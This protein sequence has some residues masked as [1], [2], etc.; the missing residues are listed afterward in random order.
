MCRLLG[1]EAAQLGR[2]NLDQCAD[3]LRAQEVKAGANVT[4]IRLAR[5]LRKT[6]LDAA[7]NDEVRQGIE[8]RG[9]SFRA[10][11]EL[12]GFLPCLLSGLST[13]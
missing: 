10:A 7:V 1:E 12:R 3:P 5:Q 2:V 9:L 4:L 13:C 11:S 6:A 8:H